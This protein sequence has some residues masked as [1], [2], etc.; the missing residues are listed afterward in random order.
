MGAI[1]IWPL[2]ARSA[3]F[4]TTGRLK[5]SQLNGRVMRPF[6]NDSTQFWYISGIVLRSELRGGRAI[7][8]LLSRAIGCWLARAHIHFPCDLL[9]LAYS[10]QG[11]ALLEGFDFFKLQNAKAM[12]DGVPLFALEVSDR[13]QLL[14]SLNSKGVDPCPPVAKPST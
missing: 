12:P 5:E 13:E 6:I 7:K 9:A 11:Q 10:E 14:S 1:G 4:F 2:S 3:E 8:I